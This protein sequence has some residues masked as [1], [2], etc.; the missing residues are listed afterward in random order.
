MN[1]SDFEV[2]MRAVAPALTELVRVATAP[3][4]ER[5]AELEA[6]EK[7]API[8]P[9]PMV[10]AAIEG[11]LP[12]AVRE[13]VA[14]LPPAEPGRD[15]DPTEIARMV[16]EAVAALPTPKDGEPGQS[17]DLDTVRLM[18]A[19]EVAK[20]PL[21]E[22]GKDADPETIRSMVSEAVDA[23]PTPDIRGAVEPVLIE[24]VAAKVG[25]AVAALPLAEPGK[26]AD[27]EATAELVRS[28]VERAV[29]ALPAPKDGRSVT[30][31]ELV[32]LIEERL[33]VIISEAVSRIPAPK[34][35][36]PGREGAPGKLGLVRAWD[37]QVFYESDVVTFD[38]GIYQAQR[39][40]GHAPPHE[41]WLC[42][43]SRG[44]PGA[45][46]QSIEVRGTYDAEIFLKGLPAYRALNI[47][48]LN[49]GSFIAKHDEPGPCPGDG[50]QLIASQ[51]KRGLPG[52]GTRGDP[53]RPGP[54]VRTIEIDDQGMLTLI[55]ADGTKVECDLYPLL[56]QI[57]STQP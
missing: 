6:R 16:N 45:D 49:G 54:S 38:G 7:A 44:G 12:V 9:A 28:E 19:D 56:A 34:D 37:D 29:S 46:A 26:D 36:E 35:G 41:D 25:E 50:W 53:G 22:P 21:A 24:M 47:V 10:H 52:E 14:S 33:P 17:V 31:E 30:P 15:A 32:P 51:G 43:V 55:N 27:P 11:A 20:L 5:I 2:V 23:L 40:T 57:A 3:L 42:I 39:D 4:T 13:A 18:V 48:A 1:R 8:D